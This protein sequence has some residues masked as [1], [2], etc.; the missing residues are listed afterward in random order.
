MGSPQG[1]FFVLF[2]LLHRA[3]KCQTNIIS[4]QLLLIII[5]T[6]I[7]VFLI[8]IIININIAKKNLMKIEK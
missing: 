2:S 6:I 4:Q 7:P 5:V 3:N 1:T 8:L